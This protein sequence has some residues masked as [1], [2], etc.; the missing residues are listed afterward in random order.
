MNSFLDELYD[1][2]ELAEGNFAQRA[3]SLSQ[4]DDDEK[5][6]SAITEQLDDEESYGLMAD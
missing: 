3:D 2:E 5:R 1:L 6:E 4:E